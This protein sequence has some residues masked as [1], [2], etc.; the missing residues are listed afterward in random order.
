MPEKRRKIMNIENDSN[1]ISAAEEKEV[2]MKNIS[3][4]NFSKVVAATAVAGWATGY[5]PPARGGIAPGN[6]QLMASPVPD[7]Q[8]GPDSVLVQI[9]DYVDRYEIKS[10]NAYSTAHLMVLDSLA[11]G[12]YALSYPECTKMLGPIVPGTVVPNGVR[13]PGTEFELDPV[14]ATF[15][16]GSMVRWMDFSDEGQRGTGQ[17]AVT[18]GHTSDNLAG[19]LASA[20]YLSRVRVAQGKAP[21]VMRDVLTSLIKAYEVQGAVGI[22][23]S[24]RPDNLDYVWWTKISTAAVVTKMFGG[25]W[26]EIVNA[27]SQAFV[28]A[29]T[30]RL[31]RD[32]FTYGTRKS[33]N[34]AEA[35][36]RG[37]WLALITLRGEMG[38]PFAL[39]AKKVGM[40]DV[41]FD[42]KPFQL[43][44]LGTYTMEHSLFKPLYPTEI[45][46]Q[47]MMECAVKLHPLVKDRLGDIEKITLS[48]YSDNWSR[49]RDE[50]VLLKPE[51][52]TNA[53]ARDHDIKYGTAIGLIFGNLTWD[54]YQ[55][56]V[57]VDPRIDALRAKMVIDVDKQ[58]TAD[59]ESEKASWPAAIQIQFK[60]GTLTDKVEVQY[61]LGHP[62]RRAEAIPVLTEKFKTSLGL[63]FPAKQQERILSI[64]LHQETF[65]ATPVNEFMEAFVTPENPLRAS[66]IE[67]GGASWAALQG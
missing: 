39:T 34:A 48:T 61:P 1:K 53:A 6:S 27:T 2:R 9:A 55:D 5:L 4:R 50:S 26:Q 30:L 3:R 32:Q 63:R 11:C 15:N 14:E 35:S 33:W 49:M 31:F 37:V 54:D 66:K 10:E 44:P 47:P 64:C 18:P 13:V 19:V 7:L 24:H 25:T 29:T 28:D 41:L 36:S 42:G 65:D 67:F 45:A 59:S 8:G 56:R 38:Y 51:P 58:W 60:D 23:G 43:A 57:A 17:G 20:D 21:L 62:R 16:I 52:L 22:N 46:I 40:Y 12:F